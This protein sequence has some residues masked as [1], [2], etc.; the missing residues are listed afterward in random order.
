MQVMDYEVFSEPLQKIDFEKQKLVINTISPHSYTVAKADRVFKEA[1]R[2]SD[3]LLPDGFGVVWATYELHNIS[4][5]RIAGADMHDYLL[6]RL[7]ENGGKVFY[8]GSCQS[9]LSKIEERLK[10]EYPA[11]T[12]ESHSPP[13]KSK[14]T[15]SE[16]DVMINRINQ[17]GPDVLFVG[18]TAP[19]QEKWIFKHKDRINAQTM[20]GVGAVFDFYAGTVKRS[21]PFWCKYGLEW[22]PRFLRDPVR[23]WRRIFISIPVFVL[24]AYLYKWRIY[25]EEVSSDK[26]LIKRS[27]STDERRFED[28]DKALI[29]RS[30]STD[31]R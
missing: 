29:K 9:T 25:R 23:L 22:L 5:P 16:N 7:H 19:K 10:R 20:C 8:L 31:E 4:I 28:T 21:G 15:D 18:M 17:F 26:V 13:F 27:V 24:D 11:I 30:V 2:Q 14:F 12:M 6:K 1:L 3:I